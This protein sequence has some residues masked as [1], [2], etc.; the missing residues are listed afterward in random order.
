MKPKP[1]QSMWGL[2][3]M[4]ARDGTWLRLY[5]SSPIQLCDKGGITQSRDSC[6]SKRI[7]NP[8]TER[9][10]VKGIVVLLMEHS[11]GTN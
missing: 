4:D 6:L 3:E 8:M 1:S 7:G 9:K 11:L 5:P 10:S 2:Y